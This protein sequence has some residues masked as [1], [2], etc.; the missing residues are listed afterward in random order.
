M[1]AHNTLITFSLDTAGYNFPATN[2]IVATIAVGREPR[3]VG[4]G[5][6]SVWVTNYG[7]G[8]V[9]RV[10]PANVHFIL[11]KDSA[12][13][14]DL[15]VA[16]MGCVVNGP[17][18]ARKADFGIAGGDGEGVVFAHGRPVRKVAQAEL[19]DALFAEIAAQA[20]TT[21]H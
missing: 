16:V 17:G 21:N 2:A 4:L 7:S 11:T 10:D 1:G 13:G 18:E 12:Y 5:F 20:G 3:H 14:L 6:G 8:T 9:T 15:E 19:V